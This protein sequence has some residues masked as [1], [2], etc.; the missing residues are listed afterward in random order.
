MI[1]EDIEQHRA[2]LAAIVDFSNDAILSKTPE[3]VITSWNKAAERMFGYSAEE[4]I[5]QQIYLLVPAD[6]HAE[7]DLIL[8]DLEKGIRI[9]NFETLRLTKT[10]QVKNISLSVSPIMNSKGAIVGASTIARDISLQK[11]AEEKIARNMERLEI[12][13]AVGRDIAGETNV[14]I[15]LQKITDATTKVT[16]ASFGAFFYNKTDSKGESYL[17]YALS[18][19]PREKFEQFGMPRNTAVFSKTFGGEGILRSDDITKDPRYGK[20]TPHKGMPEG[21]LPVVS[22]LAVPVIA[23]S[24]AVIGGLLFGH[25][26]AAMFSEEHEAITSA[27][28][29]QAAIVLE[30]AK[31]YEEIEFL[32][33]KKDEFIGFASHELKTPLSTIKGYLQLASEAPGMLP[34]FLPK[35]EKQVDRLGAIIADLL[36]IS[37]LQ[38]GHLELNF[39][40]TSIQSLVRDGMETIRAIAPKRNIV[41]DIPK[42]YTMITVDPQKLGQVINN[43]LTNAVKYSSPDTTVLLSA[44]VMG[45]QVRISVADNG[46]GIAAEDLKNIFNRF[47]RISRTSHDAPGLGLGLYISREIMELHRGKIW[48]E[49]EEGKGST[50]FIE[51]PVEK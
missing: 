8:A 5:G 12:L 23:P 16:G 29:G 41:V 42:E 32:N 49:S 36:D 24:G 15:I 2:M 46:P 13:N 50:F 25:P 7:E 19:A 51:F 26:E 34:E 45:D 40:T 18:G 9:E 22:Y 44:L 35:L 14:E 47:Y 3:G 33:N 28:A 11:Q 6:R 39:A 48:A 17:L 20:N 27:I 38:S 4:V 10:G 37:K 21:H 1:E 30:K 43:L 31:L